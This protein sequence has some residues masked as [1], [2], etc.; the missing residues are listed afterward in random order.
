[1]H[2]L[3]DVTKETAEISLGGTKMRWN[4]C[5]A[6]EIEIRKRDKDVLKSEDI[7]ENGKKCPRKIYTRYV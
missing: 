3:I 2:V 1:M 7:W 6:I 5:E 4:F